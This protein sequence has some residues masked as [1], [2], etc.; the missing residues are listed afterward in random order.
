MGGTEKQ[1]GSYLLHF[2][3]EEFVGVRIQR[4]LTCLWEGTGAIFYFSLPQLILGA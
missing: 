4:S 3:F 2:Y 1:K